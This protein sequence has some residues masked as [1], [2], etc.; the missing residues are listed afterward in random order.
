MGTEIQY[1]IFKEES[2]N[3]NSRVRSEIIHRGF[4]LSI[5]KRIVFCS[6]VAPGCIEVILGTD[7]TDLL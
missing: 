5:L 6:I 4:K 2:I 1:A 3:Y 7:Y